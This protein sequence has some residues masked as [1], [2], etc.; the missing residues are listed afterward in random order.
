MNIIVKEATEANNSNLTAIKTER[1]EVCH[2]GRASEEEILS[3]YVNLKGK[4]PLLAVFFITLVVVGTYTVKQFVDKATN[5]KGG[6][7]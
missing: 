6:N 3:A 7:D 1:V 2:Y 5:K 4:D